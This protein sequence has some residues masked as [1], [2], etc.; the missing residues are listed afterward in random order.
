MKIVNFGQVVVMDGDRPALTYQMLIEINGKHVPIR[1]DEE[2][3]QSLM[4][5]VQEDGDRTAGDYE[6]PERDF[7][8]DDLP[9][10]PEDFGGTEYMD[11]PGEMVSVHDAHSAYAM[12]GME[13]AIP[14]D[15]PPVASPGLGANP[16]SVN[17][18]PDGFHLRPQAKTVPADSAGYPIVQRTPGA[19]PV[20]DDDG[21]QM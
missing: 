11:D 3:V 21:V 4:N 7:R 13:D 12:G 2:T 15:P 10:G 18:D 6:P 20:D 8:T 14:A 16:A 17:V 9:A 19:Q 5:M 1:T